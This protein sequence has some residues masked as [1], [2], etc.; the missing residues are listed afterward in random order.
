M[1]LDEAIKHCLEVAERN[2]TSA[3]TYKNCKEFKTNMYEKLTAEKAESDCRECAAD[4]RQLAEWLTELKEAKRLLKAAVE[5]IVWLNE[6]TVDG[7]GH[8]LI[9]TAS[10][11]EPCLACP[12]NVNNS[13]IC[14][15]KHQVEALTLIGEDTNVPATAD[16]TNVGHESGG[17]I[18]C[19]ERLPVDNRPVLCYVRDITGEGSGYIIGSC[20]HSEFWFLKIGGNKHFSFPY[21][22]IK[23]THWMS[24][25]EPPKE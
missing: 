23:V 9:D 3:I 5:D 4:H 18:S 13:H 6:H 1:T 12:L 11:M 10:D 16:D 17:W 2:E 15:W 22:R 24:L 14:G 7:V 20:E 25:P 19:E 21:M 8:C